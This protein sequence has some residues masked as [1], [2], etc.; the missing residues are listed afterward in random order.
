MY[1]ISKSLSCILLTVFYSISIFYTKSP[2]LQNLKRYLTHPD[3]TSIK[4]SWTAIL[5]FSKET[6]YLP[7]VEITP[8][9][10]VCPGESVTTSPQWHIVLHGNI[11]LTSV[12]HDIK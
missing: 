4:P 3:N 9:A 1:L 11:Y 7:A 2:L 8:W 12:L 5:L 10:S 6:S